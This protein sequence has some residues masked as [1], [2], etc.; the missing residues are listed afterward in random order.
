MVLMPLRYHTYGSRAATPQ[1]G[2]AVTVVV[3]RNR[4]VFLTP[5]PT[6][7]L[8][9]MCHS[10]LDGRHTAM[11]VLLVAVVVG[12]D[13]LVGGRA[14]GRRADAADVPGSLRRPPHRDIGVLVA[15][16]VVPGRGAHRLVGRRELDDLGDGGNPGV[17]RDE[18]HVVARR[19]DLRRGWCGDGERRSGRLEGEGN[20]PLP[21][22]LAVGQRAEADQTHL[23]DRPSLLGGDCDV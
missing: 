12:L 8:P 4:D 11:S 2:L 10:P 14:A 16:V 6:G 22:V 3:G 18:Q 7:A 23:L 21:L 1:I 13:R 15:V 9:R 17:V 20:V 19:C 5:Q